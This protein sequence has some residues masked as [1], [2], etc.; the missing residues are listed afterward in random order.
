MMG[1]SPCIRS[2]AGL[3]SHRNPPICSYSVTLPF[4]APPTAV[5]MARVADMVWI[6]LASVLIKETSS[7]WLAFFSAIGA[8]ADGTS[9]LR[10]KQ[11]LER[12]AEKTT[13]ATSG[14]KPDD[15]RLYSGIPIFLS[16][17][18]GLRL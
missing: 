14:R 12:K 16:G 6:L 3:R 7:A 18:V 5:S 8:G 4:F 1:K 15:I 10:N 13:R 17:L 11:P 2:M 9:W